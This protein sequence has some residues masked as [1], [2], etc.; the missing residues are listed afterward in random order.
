MTDSLERSFA[1]LAVEH[2]RLVRALTR[3]VER[4]PV[5]G[6]ER[7][8]AQAR[9]ASSRLASITAES[10]F[11]LVTFDGRLFDPSLPVSA[12]NAD[13]FPVGSALCVAE[14]LEPAVVRDGSIVQLGKVALAVETPHAPRD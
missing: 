6:Q 1:A 4:M 3:L 7:V 13:E 8:A 10:G 2:W 5:E 11:R 12:V 14:T 9:F